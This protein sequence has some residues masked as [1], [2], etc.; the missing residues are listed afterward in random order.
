LETFEPGQSTQGRGSGP[1]GDGVAQEASTIQVRRASGHLVLRGKEIQVRA[2]LLGQDGTGGWGEQAGTGS[3]A[4]PPGGPGRIVATECL[5]PEEE[6]R[7]RSEA[8]TVEE[9]LAELTH[10]RRATMMSVRKLVR[11]AVPDGYQE[12]MNWGMIAWE[13]PLERFPDTYNGQ[14][15]LLAALASQKRHCSLYLQGVYMD[16]ELT[17]RLEEGFAEEELKLDMGKSCVRFKTPEDLPG[18]VIREVVSAMAPEDLIARYEA[19]GRRS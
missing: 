15:L 4:T 5:H 16:P 19:A 14:P 13:V 11:D 6:V 1:D 10:E 7:M 2:E 8:K 17:K 18:E 9:Y 3:S 12:R